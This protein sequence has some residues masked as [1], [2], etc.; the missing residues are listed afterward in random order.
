MKNKLK[1]NCIMSYFLT[2]IMTVSFVSGLPV[3][4]YNEV[5]LA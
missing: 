2:L 4:A 5:Q 3:N 1:Y